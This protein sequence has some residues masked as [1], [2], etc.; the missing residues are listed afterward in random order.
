MRYPDLRS[1]TRFGLG[2]HI[3]DFQ[4][5]QKPPGKKVGAL[6]KMDGK[7]FFVG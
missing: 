6:Q 7:N 1:R 5:F 2:Y 3:L 4:P